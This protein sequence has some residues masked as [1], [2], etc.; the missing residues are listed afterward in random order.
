MYDIFWRIHRENT[1]I[2]WKLN[3]T[4]HRPKDGQALSD[5]VETKESYAIARNKCSTCLGSPWLLIIVQMIFTSG[6]TSDLTSYISNCT[7]WKVKK[8]LYGDDPEKIIGEN[9]AR[10]SN[11]VVCNSGP[12]SLSK[13][14]QRCSHA[15]LLEILI[16]MGSK[17]INL[18]SLMQIQSSFW[19]TLPIIMA[20]CREPYIEADWYRRTYVAVSSRNG[21]RALSYS[22]CLKAEGQQAYGL[23]CFSRDFSRSELP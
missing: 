8:S 11:S 23:C 17:S 15:T 18:W 6:K 13:T 3:P 19:R 5:S 1:E 16:L 22:C 10:P 20:S 21:W 4:V 12:K 2:A 9:P 7:S 14:I